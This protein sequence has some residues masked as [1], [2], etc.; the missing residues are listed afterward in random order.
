MLAVTHIIVDNQTPT[1]PIVLGALAGA[2]SMI[3]VWIAAFESRRA[4]Q[5][6][7]IDAEQFGLH[8]KDL[9]E[10]TDKL[11]ALRPTHEPNR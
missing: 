10:R 1:W 6:N 2:G 11:L 7:V 5:H 9:N 4:A 8:I 3:G